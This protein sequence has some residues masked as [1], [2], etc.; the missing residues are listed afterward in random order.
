MFNPKK[1]TNMKK[2][3][4][5]AV[6][7]LFVSMTANAQYD[8]ESSR[9]QGE[10]SSE[11]RIVEEK[12]EYKNYDRFFFSYA[13]TRIA[14]FY[15]NGALMMHGVGM[16]WKKGINVTGKRLPLYLETGIAANFAFGHGYDVYS[17]YS[18]KN[19]DKLFNFVIPVNVSY[20]FKI[21]NTKIFIG[22]YWG[23][24]FKINYF[25]DGGSRNKNYFDYNNI[26]G[27]RFQMGT[28]FGCNFDIYNFHLGVGWGLDF[29]KLARAEYSYYY[30]DW[31]TS[32]VRVNVGVTF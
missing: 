17:D 5:L 4:S 10:T 16:G 12:P 29:M 21:A 32:G 23:L 2:C 22:P 13:P 6:V 8:Y 25:W 3:F 11:M 28:E 27:N 30:R 24:N 20:R 31:K 9:T 1:V 14:N 18:E 15:S 7:A 19:Q 26:D